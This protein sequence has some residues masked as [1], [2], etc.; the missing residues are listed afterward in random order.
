MER[1]CFQ[2]SKKTLS[3]LFVALS[4][5]ALPVTAEPTKPLE[6]HHAY[7]SQVLN[8]N[9]QAPLTGF[10]LH[11]IVDDGHAFSTAKQSKENAPLVINP[12]SLFRIA[13]VTK[14]FT[15][16]TVLRLHEE[17][18]LSLDTTLDKLIS[19]D[20]FALLESDGYALDKMT[21]KQVLSHTAGLYDHAQSDQYLAGIMANPQQDIT[22]REQIKGCVEWGDPVGKPGERFSYSDTGYVLLGHIIERVT[23][24]PLPK[25]VRQYLS[26]DKNHIENVIWERGD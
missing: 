8:A 15:A 4:L 5:M 26:F 14:T 16:A 25:A 23:D 18:K 13:S 12:N 1:W 17:G 20:F 22:M 10:A 3:S 11:V 7:M 6:T 24:L 21:L 2:A 9:Q 19:D